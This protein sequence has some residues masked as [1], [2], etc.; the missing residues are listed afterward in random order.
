MKRLIVGCDGTWQSADTGPAQDPSNV[1]NICRAL[2]Y[3]TSLEKG[4]IQQIVLYQPGVGSGDLTA[5]QHAV[6]GMAYLDKRNVRVL[7]ASTG[8]TGF[9]LKEN[10]REAYTFIANNYTKGDEIFL[11]GFSR[12]AY[13]SRSVAALIGALG[14]LTKTGLHHFKPIYELYENAKT[15]QAWDK[16]LKAYILKNEPNGNGWRI[17]PEDV[18][19]KVVGCWETVGALGVPENKIAEIFHLNDKWKFL[20]TQLPLSTF[21]YEPSSGGHS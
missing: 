10:S 20:D 9:G 13:T 11:F 21:S 7:I 14:V 19:I 5:V 15:H 6:S 1:T 16:S 12:G 17:A 3:S 8:S 4:S 2:E 18:E